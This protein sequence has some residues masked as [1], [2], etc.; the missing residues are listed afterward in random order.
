MSKM[1]PVPLKKEYRRYYKS[2]LFLYGFHVF[3]VISLAV[4]APFEFW[5]GMRM[6]DELGA[7]FFHTVAETGN[8]VAYATVFFSLVIIERVFKM[9]YKRVR[10]K[11]LGRALDYMENRFTMMDP[12]DPAV[13]RAAL[14]KNSF[15][16]VLDQ[17]LELIN[18]LLLITTL[19]VICCITNVYAGAPFILVS[20][21]TA[22]R[23]IRQKPPNR[24][25]KLADNALLQA[26]LFSTI[27]LMIFHYLSYG[28][29]LGYYAVILVRMLLQKNVPEDIALFKVHTARLTV[30][31][32]AFVRDPVVK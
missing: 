22:L 32:E 3:L 24:W 27:L 4:I 25:L 17:K 21:V 11:E 15:G 28:S 9:I 19:S 29:V 14:S 31:S 26:F 7:M 16:D 8:P 18:T 6:F 13:E 23:D 20:F 5:S 30:L 1:L 12:E 10:L 2:R